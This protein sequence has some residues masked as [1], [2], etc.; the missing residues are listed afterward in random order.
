MTTA[1]AGRPQSYLGALEDY[2]VEAKSIGHE[3]ILRDPEEWA[4][5]A[6]LALELDAIEVA[7]SLEEVQARLPLLR[8][9]TTR[10]RRHDLTE[11]RLH[12]SIART[13]VGGED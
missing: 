4:T 2:A 1:T 10:L 11:N 8:A 5:L 6:E 13:A 7:D 9:L 3:L 12:R